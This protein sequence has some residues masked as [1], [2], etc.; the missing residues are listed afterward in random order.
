MEVIWI[1]GPPGIGKTVLASQLAGKESV[2][3]KKEGSKWFEAYDAHEVVVF[4]DIRKEWFPSFTFLLGLLD[5]KAFRVECKGSSRQFLAKKII[6]TSLQAPQYC[7]GTVGNEPV[8]QLTRRITRVIDLSIPVPDVPEVAEVIIGALPVVP[9]LVRANAGYFP[10]DPTWA[11]MGA[12]DPTISTWPS[13]DSV[14]TVE[15]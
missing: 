6:L 12:Y 5:T 13:T 8:L 2:Y 7:F 14:D 3:W 10:I 15:M 4:D 1:H 11:P 9:A